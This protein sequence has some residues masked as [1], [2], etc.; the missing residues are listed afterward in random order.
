M[1]S[2]KQTR[3]IAMHKFQTKVVQ[4]KGWLSTI[5]VINRPL[6]YDS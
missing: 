5:V 4:S 6:R 3:L 1:F 2:P